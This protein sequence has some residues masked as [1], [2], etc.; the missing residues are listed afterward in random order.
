[1]LDAGGID[2]SNQQRSFVVP[3]MELTFALG[4]SPAVIATPN[5]SPDAC[6][7]NPGDLTGELKRIDGCCRA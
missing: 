6:V 3:S 1:V 2:L 4:G 5:R 7:Y